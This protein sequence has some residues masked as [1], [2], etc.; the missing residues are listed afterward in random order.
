M[1]PERCIHDLHS[2]PSTS[3]ISQTHH[4]RLSCL[5]PP[6]GLPQ[7][8]RLLSAR[9]HTLHTRDRGMSR[10]PHAA[11]CARSHRPSTAVQRV[12]T[13]V[14]CQWI[15]RITRRDF[16]S[17]VC[18]ADLA[19]QLSTRFAQ[20]LVPHTSH[21]SLTPGHHPNTHSSLCALWSL[22]RAAVRT[23]RRGKIMDYSPVF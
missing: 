1:L 14:S 11:A 9:A 7:D 4:Q 5:I 20:G 12:E 3:V 23:P 21:T 13:L 8:S 16:N 17:D 6:P 22:L 18:K 15:V 19:L 10:R 2:S